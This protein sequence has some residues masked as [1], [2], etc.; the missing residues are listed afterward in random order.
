M[1]SKLPKIAFIYPSGPDAPG[2]VSLGQAG[3]NTRYLKRSGHSPKSPLAPAFAGDGLTFDK[4]YLEKAV[5]NLRDRFSP[6]WE[7]IPVSEFAGVWFS[8]ASADG[9]FD[10]WESKQINTRTFV[11]KL[12]QNGSVTAWYP[13]EINGGTLLDVKNDEGGFIL[14]HRVL[15]VACGLETQK[16]T[17]P[18]NRAPVKVPEPAESPGQLRANDDIRKEF[19]QK[20]QRARQEQ[21]AEIAAAKER[22]RAWEVKQEEKR[23][24]AL[25]PPLPALPLPLPLTPAPA[26]VAALPPP[27]AVDQTVLENA[28]DPQGKIDKKVVCRD[29]ITKYGEATSR[30]KRIDLFIPK[31]RN[32]STLGAYSFLVPKSPESDQTFFAQMV[33]DNLKPLK[34][35]KFGWE[36][37]NLGGSPPQ[38]QFGFF[39]ENEFHRLV[40]VTCEEAKARFVK[41]RATI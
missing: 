3:Y 8:T 1:A 5:L 11:V 38:P 29:I 36:L 22:Q 26:P 10:Q 23:Q 12:M 13:G 16:P 25:E 2:C 37:V 41:A 28:L 30:I 18:A 20:L 9:L 19:D 14:L 39:G 40:G 32:P 33:Y 21:E 17:L 6:N 4:L 34:T 35:D 27:V 7:K 31:L 15:W 24:T